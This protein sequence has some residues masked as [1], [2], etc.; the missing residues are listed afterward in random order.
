MVRRLG[1]HDGANQG[2][3]DFMKGARKLQEAKKHETS[4]DYEA[5]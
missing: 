1:S 4:S 5:V 2:F 3:T